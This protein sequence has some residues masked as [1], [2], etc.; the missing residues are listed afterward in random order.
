M[1]ISASEQVQSWLAALSPQTKHGV[2][3][4]L[5]TLVE[6]GRGDGKA[7]SPPLDGFHRLR[8]G[9]YRVIY[10]YQPGQIIRLEYADL[11]DVI[12]ERF[13]ERVSEER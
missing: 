5:Q 12:Y 7:L 8:I 1:R 13:L 3:L 11:R 6:E 4:A 9:G 2:R 10:T